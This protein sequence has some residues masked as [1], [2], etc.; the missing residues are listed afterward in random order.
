[1]ISKRGE[2]RWRLGMAC[3]IALGAWQ[4]RQV[5]AQDHSDFEA[6]YTLGVHQYFSEDYQ[7]AYETLARAKLIDGN[8]PRPYYFRGLAAYQLGY[9][10]R[11][12]FEVG[13]R[14]EARVAGA[15]TLVNRALERVQ[16]PLRLFLEEIRITARLEHE[17]SANRART[18]R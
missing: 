17:R 9:D 13:A 3:A 16:G 11:L 7:A 1:M 5:A 4:V 6:M 14:V 12:D 2:A 18:L 15:A 8:D 10:G